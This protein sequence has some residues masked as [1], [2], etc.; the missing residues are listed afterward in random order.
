V[1]GQPGCGKTTLLQSVGHEL[2]RAGRIAAFV[3]LEAQ[4]AV[5]DLGSVEMHLAAIAALLVEAKTSATPLS[6][7]TLD[8]CRAW[9]DR[10][11][12]GVDAGTD[13]EVIAAVFR[14]QLGAVQESKALRD[15]L[16]DLVKRG[17]SEDPQQLL[18]QVLGDLASQRPVV[19]L[20]G[21]DKLPPTQA[22]D[23][24][25]D[26]KKKPMVE[27]PG[28]AILTI[29][30]SIVYEPTFNVLGERYNN[31]G[32]AVL[33][34]V[35]P[36]DLDPLTR[37]RTRSENGLAVL[38]RIISVRVDPVDPAIVLPEAVDRAVIGSGGNIRE[39]ARLMQASVVKAAFR[40]G[41]FIEPQD[42]EAAIADQRES[43]RRGY[44]PR[45]LD[46]LR[47]VH[48]RYELEGPGDVTKLLLY[49]LWVTEYRNGHG[50]YNLPVPVEQLLE[51]L[52][53]TRS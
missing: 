7:A 5:Q 52:E 27:L 40:G 50:W 12:G 25:L 53:R 41:A 10:L 19:I 20:D 48:E 32:S 26:D 13:P 23:T 24:F 14:R 9:L 31:A 37:K 46:V 6:A 1:A 3:D 4:T 21:L 45:F 17:T 16:R 39:L 15:E 22:R 34:A 35:R 8:A 43:F 44:E 29:P 51:H 11:L 47:K 28:T 38:R 2:R 42:I 18:A 30:L 36:W 33:P 49:G